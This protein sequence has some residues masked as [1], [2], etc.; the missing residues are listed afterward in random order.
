MKTLNLEAWEY[1]QK[2]KERKWTIVHDKSQRRWGNLVTNILES[3]N[4]TPREVRLMPMKAII[5]C[6]FEKIVEQ[7]R[8][9]NEN[10]TKCNT[11]LPLRL[12]RLFQSR[13]LIGQQYV[14]TKFHHQE[15]RY[16]VLSRL[17]TNEGG[18]NV[19]WNL[20]IEH[21]LAVSG[22]CWD[23]HAPM[24]LLLVDRGAYHLILLCTRCTPL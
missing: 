18:G 5:N 9:H 19:L 20:M 15:A 12:L 24:Q 17:Q 13:D 11:S 1:L 2:I 23:S 10:A 3:F 7:Y 16:R 22:K 4:N 21:A 14:I 8:K 6:T